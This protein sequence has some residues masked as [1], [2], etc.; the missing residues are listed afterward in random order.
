MLDTSSNPSIL[1][2]S[3]NLLPIN[4][5]K[6][7]CRSIFYRTARGVVSVLEFFMALTSFFCINNTDHDRLTS[8]SST[9]IPLR[10]LVR[11]IS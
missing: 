7:Y 11:D 3:F 8:S 5:L 9:V 4:L 1:T 2:I 6:L 10:T